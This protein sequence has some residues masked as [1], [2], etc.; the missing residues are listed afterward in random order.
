LAPTICWSYGALPPLDG[1][2]LPPPPDE[3]DAPEDPDEPEDPLVDDDPDDPEDESELP[4]DE[5]V[6]PPPA[7]APSSPGTQLPSFSTVPSGHPAC[8]GGAPPHPKTASAAVAASAIRIVPVIMRAFSPHPR[9]AAKL[10]ERSLFQTPRNCTRLGTGR[11]RKRRGRT[12]RVM[13][14]PRVAFL[15][16]GNMGLPMARNV[17]KTFDVVTWNRTPKSHS[18]LSTAAT[19]AA[20]ADGAKY[21]VTVLS[22]AATLLDVLGRPDGILAKLE[23]GAVVIDMATT[24]RRGAL[25][26]DVAVRARGGRFVDCPVSGT[27]APAERG[28]LV[29]MVGASDD[30]FRE[31][32]PL[33]RTMC[34]R[35][36]HAGGPGQGQA[37]KVVLNGVG[38]H[39]FVAFASMLALGERAGLPREAIV[40][41]FTSGAFASPSYVGKRS[42]VLARDYAPE[43]A[44][45]LAKKDI[46]LVVELEEEVGLPLP[47]LRA[48]AAE[49]EGGVGDGLGDD[50]LFGLERRFAKRR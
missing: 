39:H 46:G 42:K 4:D 3:S 2:S 49:I 47:V 8:F 14:A 32:E 41:A 21:V 30:D 13:S 1:V 40:D 48:L 10:M 34:A 35:L 29:G 6:S 11:L 26:A 5:L 28:A 24:G 25:A 16:L 23:P 15:G 20:C 17:A 33:L 22:D 31:V 44:L 7:I 45:A 38:S 37:L 9:R 50:D 19:P 36:I 12:L 27:V 43:F 18:G